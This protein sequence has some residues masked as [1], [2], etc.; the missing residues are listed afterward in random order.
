MAGITSVEIEGFR[1]FKKL[2]VDGLT[3]VTVIVE[4]GRA[5]V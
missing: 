3:P 4:I 5:H 1:C 2:K